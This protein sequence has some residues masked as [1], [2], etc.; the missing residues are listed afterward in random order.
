MTDQFPLEIIYADEAL[1][2]VNKPAGLLSIQDGYDHAMPHLA[3]CLGKGF[4]KVWIVHRLDRETS[5]VIIVAR[6]I[7]AHRELN[8]QFEHRRVQKTYHAIIAGFPEWEYIEVDIPLRVNG[9]RQHRTVLSPSVGKPAKTSFRV[10]C[11]LSN[12]CLIEAHP[13][14]GYTHQIRA[15]LSSLGF[16]ILGDKLYQNRKNDNSQAKLPDANLR[17]Y[18]HACSISFIHPISK[19]AITF[20]APYPDDFQTAL[21]SLK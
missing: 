2:A 1:I 8:Q 15:H 18:L 13:Q 6:S 9:D 12:G 7:I 16:P 11:R 20:V 10:I 17:T 4:G 14:T 19:K 21:L 3:T 5:G